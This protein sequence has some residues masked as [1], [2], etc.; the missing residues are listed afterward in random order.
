[1]REAG[2]IRLNEIYMD[3]LSD[4]TSETKDKTE[5]QLVIKSACFWIKGPSLWQ[6]QNCA[7]CVLTK[8]F[9]FLDNTVSLSVSVSVLDACARPRNAFQNG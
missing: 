5:R 6:H 3:S 8:D 7:K 1:M 9:G 4:Q 2:G